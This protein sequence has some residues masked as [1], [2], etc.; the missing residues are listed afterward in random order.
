M[1]QWSL[2]SL[3]PLWV[4][5]GVVWASDRLELELI[6]RFSA[7]PSPA[8]R[9]DSDCSASPR[10][11]CS[12]YGRS[13]CTL[14]TR[15]KAEDRETEGVTNEYS[16]GSHCHTES[17]TDLPV[18]YCGFNFSVKI[19]F[20]LFIKAQCS[21]SMSHCGTIRSYCYHKVRRHSIMVFRLWQ[22]CS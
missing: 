18:S 8:D 11:T 4:H 17:K 1:L 10:G 13:G 9:G 16:Q 15:L 19:Y 6:F 21:T 14:P 2:S 7:P 12:S 5:T 20:F 3:S 22:N